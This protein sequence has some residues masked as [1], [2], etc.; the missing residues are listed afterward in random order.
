MEKILKLF[1][2]LVKYTSFLSCYIKLLLIVLFTSIARRF[3]T[4]TLEKQ[5]VEFQSWGIL[6][7]WNNCYRTFDTQYIIDEIRLFWRLYQQVINYAIFLFFFLSI[8]IVTFLKNLLYRQ[9]K[10]VNWSP[11]VHSALAESELEYNDQHKRYLKTIFFFPS[12]QL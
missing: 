10:P 7:D 1:G 2:N 5:K 11:T 8:L 12:S 9:Y 3:A 6:A 4:E